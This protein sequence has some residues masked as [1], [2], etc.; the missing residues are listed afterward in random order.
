VSCS[1][2]HAFDTPGA[3]DLS[4]RAANVVPGDWDPSNN[5]ASASIT[6][7]APGVS[8]L[9][10]YLQVYDYHHGQTYWMNY[11]DSP[12]FHDY[13][14]SIDYDYGEAYVEGY[15]T[16]FPPQPFQSMGAEI[17]VDGSSTAATALT[18]AYTYGYDSGWYAYSCTQFYGDSE[19]ASACSYDWY[20][21]GGGYSAYYNALIQ[22]GTITYYG[23]NNYCEYYGC[24]SYTWN[25]GE[26]HGTPSS[27]GINDGSSVRM[28]A[29]FV[30]ATGVN[31][32]IDH[33]LPAMYGIDYGANPPWTFCNPP[34]GCE[35]YRYRGFYR[36][37]YDLW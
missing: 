3:Y 17:K 35:G 9:S 2:S 19:S 14:S 37:G 1:F 25:Y 12:Y 31:H 11:V 32:T 30:D 8:I 27:F 26:V 10:G 22:R 13:E 36:Y 34:Y 16:A 21:S 6:I 7:T 4:V 15:E 24:D 29:S 23:H 20:G 28:L 5:S 33:T 18:A